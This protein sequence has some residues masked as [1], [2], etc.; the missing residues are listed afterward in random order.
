MNIPPQ[1]QHQQPA[2]SEEEINKRIAKAVEAEVAK[3]L[4][5]HE[6]SLREER[7]KER[8]RVERAESERRGSM[9]EGTSRGPDASGAS[10]SGVSG[11]SGVSGTSGRLEDPGV[12]HASVDE[13]LR[14]RL[15]ELEQR[16]YVLDLLFQF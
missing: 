10:A 11:V 12:G 13:E 6:R 2:L 14:Q 16:L 4:A 8:E 15:S 5:E 3:R 1:L 7:D 9:M